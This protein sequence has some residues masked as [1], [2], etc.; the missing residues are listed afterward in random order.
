MGER[1]LAS[2]AAILFMEVLSV[3]SRSVYSHYEE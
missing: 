3:S 2:F 1:N